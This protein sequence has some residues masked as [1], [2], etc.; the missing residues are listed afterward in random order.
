MQELSQESKINMGISLRKEKF[1]ASEGIFSSVYQGKIT[2][3]VKKFDGILA[4]HDPSDKN[5]FNESHNDVL[6]LLIEADELGRNPLDIACYLGFRNIA[7]YLMSKLGS[8]QAVISQ[9][10][11]VDLERRTP[12][13]SICYK[14]HYDTMVCLLN[15]ERVYL[16]KILYD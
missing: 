10:I 14:G 4:R 6:Q 15:L 13:H 2:E 16:K 3:I 5:S 9:E 1:S 11:N 8:P 7:I 12:Y